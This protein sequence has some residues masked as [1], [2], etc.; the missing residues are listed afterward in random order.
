M[1]DD[2]ENGIKLI[3]LLEEISG[4]K[5]IPCNKNPKMRVQMLENTG[6]ALNFIKS[7]GLKL[8]NIG[9]ENIVDK[10]LKLDLGLIWTLILRYQIQ[11]GN[12]N[13][14]KKELLEW[15]NKMIRPYDKII[16]NFDKD[17][18]DGQVMSALSDALKPG[19]LF[20]GRDVSNLSGDAVN[21]INKA[22]DHAVNNYN[23]PKIL[24]PQDM[25]EYPDELSTMTYVSYF[26]DWFN[27]RGNTDP[28]RTYAEGPGLESGHVKD[29]EPTHF[30]IHTV[31]GEGNPRGQGGDNFDVHIAGPNGDVPV[32]VN[33]NGDGTYTVSYEP[34]DVGNHVIDVKLGEHNIK[35]APFNVEVVAG[36]DASLSTTSIHSTI[37]VQ[38]VD[39]K[40]QPK[41]FGGDRFEVSID[42]KGAVTQASARDN[43]DGTYSADFTI[44]GGQGA[45][46]LVHVSI[47]GKNVAGSPYSI[48]G[49]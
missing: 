45:H 20:P 11:K 26:R 40:G 16:T 27:N 46:H 15:V 39:K 33:D 3:A 44:E 9:P 38:S 7:E 49:Q 25:H 23:I 10:N 47:N 43:G 19:S 48:A 13:S 28:L 6:Q 1:E 14:G 18:T 42:T 21:D 12:D 41:G 36:T 22:M 5:K 30:T 34:T 35:D 17:W 31:D 4:G 2:L 32:S 8:V 29:N 37:T 24:D